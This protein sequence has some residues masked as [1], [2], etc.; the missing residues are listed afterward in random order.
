[1]GNQTSVGVGSLVGIREVKG[2]ERM[3]T[4]FGVWVSFW[5]FNYEIRRHAKAK[6]KNGV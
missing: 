6:E 3:I 1:M 4:I 5:M 2:E